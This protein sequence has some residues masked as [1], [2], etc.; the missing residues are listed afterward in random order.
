MPRST[1]RATARKRWLASDGSLPKCLQGLSSSGA[2]AEPQ[3]SSPDLPPEGHEPN[4]LEPSLLPPVVC[5]GSKLEAEI[6]AGNQMWLK[7]LLGIAHWA[8]C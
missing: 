1:C 7:D 6:R 8:G 2:T 4:G 3:G 5:I